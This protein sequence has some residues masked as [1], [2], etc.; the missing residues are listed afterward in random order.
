MNDLFGFVLKMGLYPLFLFLRANRLKKSIPFL[1]K[2]HE[3]H[4]CLIHKDPTPFFKNLR[5][6]LDSQEEFQPLVLNLALAFGQRPN[7]VKY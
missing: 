5:F 7:F 6:L 2:P 3:N 4:N 1:I